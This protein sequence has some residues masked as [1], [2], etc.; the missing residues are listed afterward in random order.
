MKQTLGS[1][2]QLVIIDQ[3]TNPI[4]STISLA[5]L[6]IFAPVWQTMP[7]ISMEYHLA[8]NRTR[9]QKW[10]S[11]SKNN[12]FHHVNLLLLISR[13]IT[14]WTCLLQVQFKH[15]VTS[16]LRMWRSIQQV[17]QNLMAAQLSVY[18]QVAD[19]LIFRWHKC[20]NPNCSMWS[21]ERQKG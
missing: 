4:C 3:W 1:I 18:G 5:C 14:Q 20:C 2:R 16:L 17:T 9:Y 12:S 10:Q 13:A 21:A 19:V 6:M 7:A 15:I 8:L 11:L